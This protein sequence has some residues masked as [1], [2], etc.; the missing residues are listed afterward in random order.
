ML[1][2]EFRFLAFFLV[3]FGVYWTMRANPPRKL[4]L[5]GS[6]YF[7]YGCWNW[8]YLFL[9]AFSTTVDFF[10][11][12]ALEQTTDPRIRRAWLLLSLGVNLGMLGAFKYY[13][14]F[15]GSAQDFLSVMGLH[16]HLSTLAF[17]LPVASAS[18]RS[19]R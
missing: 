18:S 8:K 11:G 14:F 3:V 13:N 2:V 15:I 7:F 10:V 9:I 6:S 1:F 16:P 19:N 17:I 12:R 5:L 4:W